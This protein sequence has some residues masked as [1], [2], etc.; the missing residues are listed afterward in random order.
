MTRQGRAVEVDHM[1][2]MS[3][4]NAGD[5]RIFCVRKLRA[6]ALLNIVPTHVCPVHI[7][8]E[9]LCI[10]VVVGQCVHVPICGSAPHR[11]VNTCTN[12]CNVWQ[13]KEI[14]VTSPLK[15]LVTSFRWSHLHI[16]FFVYK[17]DWEYCVHQYMNFPTT[18]S[19][20][21]SAT[22]EFTNVWRP[23]ARL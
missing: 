19:S 9:F 8:I 11:C 5:V 4:S 13:F 20:S 23:S 12:I 10:N 14:I 2:Y 7:E 21:N 1:S 16:H 6:T 3:R 15:S 18:Q 17:Q 22:S